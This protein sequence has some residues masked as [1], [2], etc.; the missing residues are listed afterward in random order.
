MVWD[1]GVG[2]AK[3]Q[4]KK[5]KTLTP[6]EHILFQPNFGIRNLCLFYLT[7]FCVSSGVI[8]LFNLMLKL[9]Y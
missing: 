1:F 8:S 6:L 4:I 9:C 5:E 3:L 2:K 7:S